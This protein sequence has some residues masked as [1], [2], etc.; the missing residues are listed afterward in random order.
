MFDADGK[1][2]TP[3]NSKF[4]F[5]RSTCSLRGVTDLLL[6]SNRCQDPRLCDI[7]IGDERNE[8][9]ILGW[10][11]FLIAIHPTNCH[12]PLSKLTENV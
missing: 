9:K 2:K 7:G 6:S 1:L 11:A 3:L 4:M 12:Q 10:G 8:K 5:L